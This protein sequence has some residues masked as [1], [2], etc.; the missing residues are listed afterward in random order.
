MVAG[1]QVLLLKRN[2]QLVKGTSGHPF[3]PSRNHN[4]PTLCS[5]ICWRKQGQ[6]HV[7][8]WNLG[9]R[10]QDAFSE[11]IAEIMEGA[12]SWRGHRGRGLLG[13]QT[14]AGGHTACLHDV[15]SAV[16]GGTGFGTILCKKADAVNKKD[17][18]SEAFALEN[19]PFWELVKA[20]IFHSKMLNILL[21]LRQISSW[22][23]CTA[24]HLLKKRLHSGST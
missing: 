9:C 23:K 3:R 14:G 24:D 21:S 12:E 19:G 10:T 16:F 15:S 17:F 6:Y 1:R 18:R 11:L 13:T 8:W 22:S 4:Q 5:K 2:T 7:P 20:M